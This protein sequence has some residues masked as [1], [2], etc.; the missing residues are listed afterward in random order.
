MPL[1]RILFVCKKRPDQYGV[2]YGLLNSCRFLCNALQ[3]IGVEAKLVEVID[4][5][6]IDREVASYNPSHVFI[7][8]LWVVPEK[9]DVLIPLHPE[10]QWHVRIH[11][12]SPFLAN[13]GVAIDWIKKYYEK[14]LKYPT[15]HIA[16]N[17]IHLV[18]DLEQSLGIKSVFA[19][20]IYCPND[21]AAPYELE[22]RS[23]TIDIGC[24]GAI[25]PMKNQ[26]LQA[27]A[28]MAFAD[29]ADKKLRFHVNSSRIEQ[30]GENAFRNIKALFDNHP[31]HVLIEHGWLDHPEFMGVVSKMDIGLQVSFSET[32]NIVAADFAKAEV[33]CVGSAEIEWMNWMYKA[34]PTDINSIVGYLWIAY[35]GKKIGLHKLNTWGLNRYNAKATDVWATL[36]R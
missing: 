1:P 25:R 36:L 19:P 14:V 23:D 9:F 10:V 11:S 17:S 4:N 35:F 21:T 29:E 8:A 16:P 15:F 12:N 34:D 27:M 33:P 30:K 2:S 20:N 28:A 24:F 3:A 7:E 5:N 22:K 32:F 26:L 31:H 18:E 13:E 6:F